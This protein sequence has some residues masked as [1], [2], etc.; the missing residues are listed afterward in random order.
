MARCTAAEAAKTR[1]R[2]L[3]AALEVFW[4]EG[5]ARPSLTRVGER[6]GMTR[7][8]VYGHFAN[9][10]D[11][12]AALCDRYLLPADVLEAHRN[13]GADDPLGTLTAWL[14]DVLRRARADREYRM[15]MEILFLKCEAVEGD[16]V[17]DRL[18][19]D[20]RRA[21]HHEREL[22]A[23]AVARGQAPS[24]LDVEAATTTIHGLLGGLIRL[25]ALDGSL[26]PE[27]ILARL[28]PLVVE[29]LGG[30]ALRR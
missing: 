12:F 25:F 11:L 20:S 24:D 8:A 2:L 17:R 5:V 10:T 22:L 18:Q 30:T 16:D 19:R 4:E 26:D 7:G 29:L 13:R 1:E 21:R 27:P 14:V 15:L 3:D 9:K 23:A 28:G 6:A